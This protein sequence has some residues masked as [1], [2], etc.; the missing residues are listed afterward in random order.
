MYSVILVEDNI[1]ERNILKKML[2][3]ISE[4]IKIYEADSEATALNIIQ[5][6]DINMF[7]IDINLKQSS[8]LD[9]AMKIRSISK[10]EFRQIIFLTTH[11][12]YITQAFKKTHCY[13]YILKPYDHKEV[14]VMLNKL[15]LN[16][17]SYKDKVEEKELVITL[18]SGIYVGIK[19]REIIFIE[20]IGK[21]CEVNTINGLYIANNMSLKKIM[22]LIDCDDIIQSHRSFAVNKDYISKIE[23]IDIKLSAVYFNNSSKTALLGYKFKNNVIDEFKKGKVILC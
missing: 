14:Q 20:V 10:Y 16:E 5:N 22:K 2:L 21:N 11:M 19:I 12:A 1:E 6:N 15:I 13:D 18:K 4:F 23:K 7:L 17:S 3:S 8:G 9:L